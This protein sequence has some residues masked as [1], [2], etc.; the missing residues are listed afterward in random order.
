MEV[1]PHEQHTTTCT[2]GLSAPEDCARAGVGTV[3]KAATMPLVCAF[4]GGD[5]V[6]SVA[7]SA[8]PAGAAP[9]IDNKGVSS[10]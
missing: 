10:P 1:S 2:I 9:D 3:D 8:F 4:S 5:A 6:F 7:G